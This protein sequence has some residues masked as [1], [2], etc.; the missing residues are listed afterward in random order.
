MK[1]VGEK[2]QPTAQKVGR[3]SRLNRRGEELP[4]NNWPVENNRKQ[5]D[6]KETRYRVER[7]WPC[8]GTGDMK[9]E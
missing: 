6:E 8:D 2:L 3:M 4:I 1:I 9:N 7:Q 5:G